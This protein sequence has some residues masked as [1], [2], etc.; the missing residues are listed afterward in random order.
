MIKTTNISIMKRFEVLCQCIIRRRLVALLSKFSLYVCVCINSR[1]D[2][3]GPRI[4]D[5]RFERHLTFDAAI[6]HSARVGN[7]ADNPRLLIND[8]RPRVI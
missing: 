1:P 7:T 5:R 6:G 8:F 3:G 2:L 4:S